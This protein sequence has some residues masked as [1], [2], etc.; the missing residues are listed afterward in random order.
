LS[1]KKVVVTNLIV[2]ATNPPS[3]DVDLGLPKKLNGAGETPKVSHYCTQFPEDSIG[4][5][6]GFFSEIGCFSFG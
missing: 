4:L 1:N 2:I 6:G 5:N 3:K